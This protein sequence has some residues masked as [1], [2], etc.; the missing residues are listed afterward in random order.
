MFDFGSK[1]G[2]KQNKKKRKNKNSLQ[3]SFV[4]DCQRWTSV[5]F[6]A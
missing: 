1:K 4:T 6:F 5:T 3:E 2:K